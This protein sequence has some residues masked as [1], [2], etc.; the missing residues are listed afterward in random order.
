MKRSWTLEEK[1]IFDRLV[2]ILGKEYSLYTE[3]LPN[4]T[5]NQIKGRYHN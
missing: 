3:H 4:K 5:Y 2:P 1:Q